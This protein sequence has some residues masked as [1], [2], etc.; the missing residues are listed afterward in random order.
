MNWRFL[1][2]E[3]FNNNILRALLRRYPDLDVIRAQDVPEIAGKDD[4][5]LLNWAAEQR[6]VLLSHD[7]RTVTGFAYDRVMQGESMPGVVEVRLGASI[8]EVVEDLL[9]LIEASEPEELH[10][11]VIYLPLN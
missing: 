1:L 11:R 2:D 5:T 4:P 3:N 7:V 6:R 9:L 10:N 8:G